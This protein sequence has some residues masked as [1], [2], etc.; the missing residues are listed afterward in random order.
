[1]IGAESFSSLVDTL[2][3]R[4]KVMLRV[5]AKCSSRFHLRHFGRTTRASDYFRMETPSRKGISV[6]DV[7]N[8][9]V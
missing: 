6:F 7:K 4:K 1:M 9:H 5:P 8:S 3:S 2:K